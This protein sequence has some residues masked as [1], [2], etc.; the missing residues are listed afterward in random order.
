[1]SSSASAPD[2][3]RFDAS[4]SRRSHSSRW[5]ALY[6]SRSICLDTIHGRARRH[7]LEHAGLLRAPHRRSGRPR[8]AVDELHPARR[9]GDDRLPASPCSSPAGM[10]W[11][12][13]V[14]ASQGLIDQSAT[15]AVSVS[16]IVF[17]CVVVPDRRRDAQ[18]RPV[19]RQA[20]G[21]RPHRARRRRGHR[22]P[23]R[24][25]PCHGRLLRDLHDAR[26]RRR[27]DRAA[28]RAGRS[29]SA[30]SSPAPTRSRSAFRGSPS[31]SSAMPRAGRLGGTG[32][33]GAD[34]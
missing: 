4:A 20:R 24:L 7:T 32:R 16:I 1:M 26:R 15:A 33:R 30:T 31:P 18:Q 6:A 14:L 8:R 21:R 12:L 28:V 23:A 5:A 11:L 13:L 9:R 17:C 25:H 3:D 19:T 10:F 27:A 22:L 29:A 2:N 34:A